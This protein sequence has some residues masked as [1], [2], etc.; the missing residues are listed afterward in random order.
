[1]IKIPLVDLQ[2]QYA[3]LKPEIDEAINQVIVSGQFILGPA[4]EKF[5]HGFARFIDVKY[6]VGLDSGLSALELGIRGLGI[7]AGD[8]I[9]TPANSFIASSAAISF[10]GAKPVLVDCEETSFNID[11]EKIEEKITKSTKAIM[12]VHLYGRMA[13]MGNIMKIAKKHKLLVIEDAAQAH[14]ASI[15]LKNQIKK[16]GSIGEFGAFSFYPAKNLGAFGDAGM[17]VTN[18]KQLAQKV[19]ELRNYGQTQKYVHKYLAYN[20][21]LDT[22]QAAV[23]NIKLKHLEAGNNRRLKIARLYN[24]LLQN[25]PLLTPQIP[26]NQIPAF[27]LYV[28]RTRKR[29]SLAIYLKK[30]GISTGIHYPIPIHLQPA[31]KNLGHKKGDFP[32]TEKLA[33]EILSLPLYPDLKD[34]QVE[35]MTSIIKRFF[36]S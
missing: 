16:A 15:Q 32:V 35:Y 3:S 21:R 11:P 36:T 34:S 31:Y 5:E 27:H 9:I 28:I 13:D 10:T 26:E 30:N 14:G 8:E 29:D 19:R 33:T 22:I 23:L 20:R 7:G 12:P 6:A 18:N 2:P 1:M 24:K 4:V 25:L 17:L